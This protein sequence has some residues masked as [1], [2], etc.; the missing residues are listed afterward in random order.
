MDPEYLTL[1]MGLTNQSQSYT[2][3]H[4]TTGP[5]RPDGVAFLSQMLMLD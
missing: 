4:S 3:W 5:S 1:A 2:G